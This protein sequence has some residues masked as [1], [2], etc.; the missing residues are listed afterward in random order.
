[1]QNTV[2]GQ[3]VDHGIL[4]DLWAVAG[5]EEREKSIPSTEGFLSMPGL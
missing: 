5:A 4:V 1:M 2:D 3:E